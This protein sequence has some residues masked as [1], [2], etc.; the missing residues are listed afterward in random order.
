MSRG[1]HN[2]P[3]K[4]GLASR[5]IKTSINK[6]KNSKSKNVNKDRIKMPWSKQKNI[7]S[8]VLNIC[9]EIKENG[10]YVYCFDGEDRIQFAFKTN[11]ESRKWE[12]KFTDIGA[13]EYVNVLRGSDNP[14]DEFSETWMTIHIDDVKYDVELE[15]H[16]EL[17][18]RL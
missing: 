10:E 6:Q 13:S 4:H 5:G 2:E 3:I 9:E 16:M 8:K 18:E 1:W 17:E 14:Y 12:N 11:E 15:E 7:L